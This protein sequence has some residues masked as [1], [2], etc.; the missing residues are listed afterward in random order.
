MNTYY[1]INTE[2]WGGNNYKE[3]EKI[4]GRYI[5]DVVYTNTEFTSLSTLS[6]TLYCVKCELNEVSENGMYVKIVE[7]N[8]EDIKIKTENFKRDLK[9]LLKEHN[10]QL[11]IDV[12]DMDCGRIDLLV[13]FI[14]WDGENISCGNSIKENLKFSP[15]CDPILT[16]DDIEL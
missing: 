5:G 11:C 15:F 8:N 10:A 2:N 9:N 4:W 14:S 6:S 12:D 13:D 3:L 1:K 16:A 7:I